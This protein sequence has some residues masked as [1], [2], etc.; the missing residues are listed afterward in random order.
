MGHS[1]CK[2]T[3]RP[4]R[5]STGMGHRSRAP[6]GKNAH[7]A[8]NQQS[9]GPGS[10]ARAD[11]N[12]FTRGGPGVPAARLKHAGDA[13]LD[14]AAVVALPTRGRTLRGALHSLLQGKRSGP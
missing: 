3:G 13:A 5:T 4:P 7:G 10:P 2:S 9:R 14:P 12:G 6:G 11:S 1:M 8:Q